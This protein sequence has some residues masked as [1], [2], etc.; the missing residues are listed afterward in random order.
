M[1]LVHTE[2]YICILRD[3]EFRF[4][5]R[6]VGLESG[7][8]IWIHDSVLKF[9]ILDLHAGLRVFVKDYVFAF[10]IVG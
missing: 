5:F 2:V 8:S 3:R 1:N 10:K 9:K 4:T 7:S 6:I